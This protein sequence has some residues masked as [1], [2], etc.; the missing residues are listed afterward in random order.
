MMNKPKY[1]IGDRLPNTNIFVRGV[2]TT[3]K[4]QHRYFLQIYDNHAILDE[5][6]IEMEID[7]VTKKFFV[8]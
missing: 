6:G 8:N 5:K 3:S 7:L 2:M 1:Q 4:G